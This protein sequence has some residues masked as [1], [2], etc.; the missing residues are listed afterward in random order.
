MGGAP[1]IDRRCT[2]PQCADKTSTYRMIGGCYN[3]RT[4]P[5]LGLFTSG[6]EASDRNGDCPVCGCARL[7]WRR[8]A[9]EDEIPAAFE[10]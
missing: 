7:Y 3:C 5:I 1:F 8:L 4:E 6:H 10:A 2:M 9:T